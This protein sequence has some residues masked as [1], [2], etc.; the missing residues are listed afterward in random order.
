V[1]F[2]NE[3]G[4]T[5]G[6]QDPYGNFTVLPFGQQFLL[7]S[8]TT[9]SSWPHFEIFVESLR[10]YK[11]VGQKFKGVPTYIVT[12]P[13]SSLM[14]SS[15]RVWAE[16]AISGTFSWLTMS[17]TSPTYY[18]YTPSGET[19]ADTLAGFIITWQG[20]ASNALNFVKFGHCSA[21]TEMLNGSKGP[22]QQLTWFVRGIPPNGNALALRA[23]AL[24]KQWKAQFED[25]YQSSSDLQVVSR[26]NSKIVTVVS[27]RVRPHPRY[28]GGIVNY[29]VPPEAQAFAG[30]FACIAFRRPYHPSQN[31]YLSLVLP[32][33]YVDDSQASISNSIALLMARHMG[34]VYIPAN[35]ATKL[36][37]YDEY[38]VAQQLVHQATQAAVN[39]ELQ[40]TF[41]NNADLGLGGALG[42]FA[43]WLGSKVGKKHPKL[44]AAI[45]KGGAIVDNLLGMTRFGGLNSEI[46]NL[47]ARK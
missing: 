44:G 39:T 20:I 25:R 14:D 29:G 38:F 8:S 12:A 36:Y 4:L 35:N 18:N 24:L 45:D 47:I 21:E 13:M 19:F 27:E 16:N 43:D 15:F 32:S 28:T 30:T 5:L 34:T 17:T 23:P 41:K 11:Y 46:G 2:W 42:V 7:P 10:R 6:V 33:A 37:Y 40:Q 3:S 31:I 1:A 9:T 26:S 22:L